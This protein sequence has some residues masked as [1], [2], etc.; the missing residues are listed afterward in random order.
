MVNRLLITPALA[1]GPMHGKQPIDCPKIITIKESDPRKTG[2]FDCNISGRSQISNAK[3]YHA[4]GQG[5]ILEHPSGNVSRERIGTVHHQNQINR[6]AFVQQGMGC[7]EGASQGRPQI[8]PLSMGIHND[9]ESML[10][11]GFAQASVVEPGA[12]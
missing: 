2:C 6:D 5:R 11:V 9:G 12:K 4:S 1:Y 10:W 3:A 8:N 7:F